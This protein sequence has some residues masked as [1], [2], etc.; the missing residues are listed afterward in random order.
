VQKWEYL[1]LYTSGPQW[2]DSFGE[3]GMAEPGPKPKNWPHRWGT[4][5]P[6]LNQLGQDG[7]EVVGI[8]Q[9]GDFVRYLFK[10]PVA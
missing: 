1:E 3:S 7:W 4:V 6:R 9:V 2:A 5:Q 8:T 10:R